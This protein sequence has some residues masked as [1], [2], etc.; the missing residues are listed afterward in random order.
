MEHIVGNCTLSSENHDLHNKT[1]YAKEIFVKHMTNTNRVSPM[2][3]IQDAAIPSTWKTIL[4]PSD[5]Y[6]L[7]KHVDAEHNEVYFPACS[8]ENIGR[9]FYIAIDQATSTG[10]LTLK[11][12]DAADSIDGD[13]T[14]EIGTIKRPN[15]LTIFIFG[16]N[17]QIMT[18][19]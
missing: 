17:H 9:I 14:Y 6:V 12:Y 7:F 4:M 11:V 15:D 5:S 19:N 8:G 16:L 2:L 10:P 3:R 18:L 13:T 1:L